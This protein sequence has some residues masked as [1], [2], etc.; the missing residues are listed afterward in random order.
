MNLTVW[1]PG[2]VKGQQRPRR[3][4]HGKGV[5]SPK[6][7]WHAAVMQALGRVKPA[8]P[9]CAECVCV[10]VHAFYSRPQSLMRKKDPAEPI[11][12]SKKPDRDNADKPIL[13]SLSKVGILADDKTAH[14]PIYR[15][16]VAKAGWPGPGV[17]VTVRP[18]RLWHEFATAVT[19]NLTLAGVV[20]PAEVMAG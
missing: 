15:W 10:E 6:T 13:D 7:E 5:Y 3:N 19:Q 14:G 2:L 12:Y 18:A 1:I 16:Y 8:G 9:P 20:L 17:L 11:P 4:P